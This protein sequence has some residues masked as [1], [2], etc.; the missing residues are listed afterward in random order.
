MMDVD[1]IRFFA[2]QFRIARGG[3]IDHRSFDSVAT[4]LRV[5]APSA[6]PW[7]ATK[8]REEAEGFEQIKGLGH[9]VDATPLAN[10][11]DQIADR[12]DTGGA[13]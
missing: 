10:L 4:L 13:A 3:K 12:A 9:D 6:C 11:L 5:L 1:R 2:G 7:G 8:L